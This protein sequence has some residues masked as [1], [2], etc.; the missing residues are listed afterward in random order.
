LLS[1]F[2]PEHGGDV[3]LKRR[4]TLNGL[5][6]VISQKTVLFSFRKV[7]LL[8]K[9]FIAFLKGEERVNAYFTERKDVWQ[10]AQ[11]ERPDGMRP[12]C[13]QLYTPVLESTEKYKRQWGAHE[14]KIED[15]RLP[16]RAIK[17]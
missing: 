2:S 11:N 7:P 5:H 3:P 1:L 9:I 14:E 15:N 8:S 4:L 6:G 16:K 12:A 13:R 10:T 17:E